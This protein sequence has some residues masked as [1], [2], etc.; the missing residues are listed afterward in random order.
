M[1]GYQVDINSAEGQQQKLLGGLNAMGYESGERSQALARRKAAQAQYSQVLNEPV[2]DTGPIDRMVSDYLNRFA[3][4]PTNPQG[5]VLSSTAGESERG[6]KMAE[7]QL[8]RRQQAALEETRMADDEVRDV[9][10]YGAKLFAAAGRAGSGPGGKQ[11]SP[12]QL[13]TVY[14]GARNEAAQI[15]KNIDIKRLAAQMGVDEGTA[16][17][18]WIEQYANRAVENYVQKFASAPAGPYGANNIPQQGGVPQQLNGPLPPPPWA[19]QGM[20]PAGPQ[21][22]QPTPQQPTQGMPPQGQMQ[23][24]PTTLQMP[25]GAQAPQE[26]QVIQQLQQATAM[27]QN[28]ATREQGVAMLRQLQQQ[29]PQAA[30]LPEVPS[31]TLRNKPLEAQQ[32]SAAEGV[33]KTRGEQYASV[34]QSAEAAQQELQ[35]FNMLEKIQPKTNAAANANEHLGALFNALGQDPNSELI[36]NAIKNRQSNLILDQLRNASL[37]AE[38]GVQTKSDELRIANEFPKTTDFSQAWKF[39][40][41]LGKERAQRRIERL[42][43]FDQNAEAG[44]PGTAQSGWA[45]EYSSDPLTQY[46]GGKLIFRSDFVDK[47]KQKYPDASDADAV[48]EWRSMEQDY[49]ARGGKK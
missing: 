1:A 11:P 42:A 14:N 7:M 38:K 35:A 10:S 5:A 18:Q 24:P 44:G 15:T 8:M 37:K 20:P 39:G 2:P 31:A 16:Q 9:D 23:T 22:Q 12:E 25:R 40:V 46:L 13:R 6:R 29:F 32:K 45:K 4:N 43:Y 27:A 41:K 19:P 49:M 21:G 47:F 3:Q 36:Q 17:T 26:Q 33:G 34:A 48:N 30:P 28:P